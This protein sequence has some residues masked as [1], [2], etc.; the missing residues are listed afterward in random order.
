MAGS[1]GHP[2]MRSSCKSLLGAVAED[3]CNGAGAGC[4]QPRYA[5]TCI[6]VGAPAEKGDS[7][8]FFKNHEH[9]NLFLRLQYT[10]LNLFLPR[11]LLHLHSINR[12]IYV[13]IISIVIHLGDAA[14]VV[15]FLP[16]R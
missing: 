14:G 13:I 1:L 6:Y 16:S 3:E 7:H 10:Q 15:C 5:Y 8:L 11:A 12:I 9:S 2:L 4:A